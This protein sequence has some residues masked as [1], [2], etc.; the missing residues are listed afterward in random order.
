MKFPDPKQKYP[1]HFADGSEHRGTVHLSEVIDHANFHVGA[2][3]YASDFDPPKDMAVHLAPYLFEGHPGHLHIGRY[4]QIAHG[5]RF[6]TSAANHAMDGI[7]TYPFQIFDPEEI[8]KLV[9]D[10][11]DTRVGH[12]VWLGYGALV[13]PGADIGNGVIVGAGAVVR[14][15][16]PD[17][18][19]V[20]G[21]PGA[22]QQMRFS[23]DEIE[24]LSRLAWWNWPDEKVAAARD[25]LISGDVAALAA[26]SEHWTA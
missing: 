14:G 2:F 10:Q 25:V 24:T 3:T 22:V 5:V 16:I 9:V 15:K 11:R 17:Y 26:F 4:C 18:A 23:A 6:I 21:N 1:I 8:G 13:L 12:D 7:T 19:V 20:T